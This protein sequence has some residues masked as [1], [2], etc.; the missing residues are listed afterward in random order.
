MTGSLAEVGQLF[1]RFDSDAGSDAAAR[2]RF[3]TLVTDLVKAKFP[4]ATTVEGA[5]NRDWGIDTVQGT[6]AGGT[7]RI[8]QSKY[9]LTWQTKDPQGQVRASFRSA[10]S[11]AQEQG[12]Q[13]DGWTLVVP[14]I[15]APDQLKWF[16]VG[17]SGSPPRMGS[18]LTCGMAP[19]FGIN[20]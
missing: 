20:S 8:W 6:L 3:Q 7:V 15:L 16:T 14:C 4:D 13:I 5:G 12:Y 2:S 11:H 18:R 10:I 17:Q 9:V 19:S 1:A